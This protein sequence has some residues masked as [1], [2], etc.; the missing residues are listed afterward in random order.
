LRYSIP[1][2]SVFCI[3]YQ[4]PNPRR[5]DS[6]ISRLNLCTVYTCMKFLKRN[7]SPSKTS[8]FNVLWSRLK[9]KMCSW[10]TRKLFT[11]DV[12]PKSSEYTLFPGALRTAGESENVPREV[13]GMNLLFYRFPLCT[14]S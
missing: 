11:N 9:K 7:F 12:K 3:I 4:F 1:Y 10:G 13:S 2:Q 6:G 5:L 8:I 14:W